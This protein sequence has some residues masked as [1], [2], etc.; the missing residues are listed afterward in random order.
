VFLTGQPRPCVPH[1]VNLK[2]NMSC[3]SAR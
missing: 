1:D 2:T 3:V